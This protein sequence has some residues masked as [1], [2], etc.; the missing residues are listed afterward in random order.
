MGFY[1]I[2]FYLYCLIISFIFSFAKVMSY[3][4]DDI[5]RYI[6]ADVTNVKTGEAIRLSDCDLPTDIVPLL[7][8]SSDLVLAKL[9]KQ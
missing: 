4:T 9:D 5:P 2:L 7:G 8:K 1:L 6:V 3:R